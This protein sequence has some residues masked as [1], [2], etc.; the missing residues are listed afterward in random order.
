M[1]ELRLRWISQMRATFTPQQV[2]EIG[3]YDEECAALVRRISF[4]CPD[5]NFEGKQINPMKMKLPSGKSLKGN[6]LKKFKLSAKNIYSDF[7]FHL[8]E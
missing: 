7:L 3:E 8:Y 5:F 1:F 6:E 4:K 2:I